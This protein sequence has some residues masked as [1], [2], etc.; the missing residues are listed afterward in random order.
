M[1]KTWTLPERL[2]TRKAW[3]LKVLL[4]NVLLIRTY[5]L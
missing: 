5:L 1:T 4:V 3:S 2:V